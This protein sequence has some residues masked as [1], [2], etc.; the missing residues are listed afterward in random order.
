MAPDGHAKDIRKGDLIR[1]W[2]EIKD[3]TNVYDIGWIVNESDNLYVVDD[4]YDSSL[5][6]Q[7]GSVLNMVSGSSVHYSP[8]MFVIKRLP[9]RTS[10]G[11]PVYS[12]IMNGNLVK[13]ALLNQVNVEFISDIRNI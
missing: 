11:I 7:S 13:V 12:A 6:Y 8:T 4:Y 5:I 9:K 1:S 3:N 10:T 2:V